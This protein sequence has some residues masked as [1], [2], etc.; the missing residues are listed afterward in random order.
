MRM[1]LLVVAVVLMTGH[2]L[3]PRAQGESGLGTVAVRGQKATGLPGWPAGTLALINDPLRTGGWHHF[4]SECPN[5]SQYYGLDV[6]DPDDVNH[7][8][9][10]LAAIDT[11]ELELSILPETGASHA[12]GVGAVFALGNQPILDEWFAGLREVEPGVRAFGVHRFREAP[13]AQPPTLIVYSKHKAVDLKR[14]KIPLKIDVTTASAQRYREDHQAAFPEIDFLVRS[15]RM[16]RL[17]HLEELGAL[18]RFD[19]AETQAGDAAASRLGGVT[20]LKWL[21]LNGTL[22][23]DAGLAHLARLTELR[24]L[25]LSDTS[26]SD[27]GVAHLRGLTKLQEIRLFKSKVSDSGAEALQRALPRLEIER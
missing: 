6:R 17:A 16:Q 27:A 15:H 9:Q 14:L 18:R 5:D 4:F 2:L 3:L 8:I 19:L 25:V 21:D 7:L 26:I 20:T 24:Y 23:T 13:P 12:G 11:T 22:I 1:T 10:L